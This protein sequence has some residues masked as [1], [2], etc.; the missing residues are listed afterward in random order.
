MHSH[1]YRHPDIFKDKVVVVAGTG[2]SGQDICLDVALEAKS[3]LVAASKV[4]WIKS[5]MPSKITMRHRISHIDQDG[6]VVFDDGT[7]DKVDA[8]LCC[9]GYVFTYACVC[10]S[11]FV[12]VTQSSKFRVKSSSDV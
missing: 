8:I 9:T 11:I 7:V 10:F 12:P 3:V 4:R 2:A 6:R 5:P 1:D